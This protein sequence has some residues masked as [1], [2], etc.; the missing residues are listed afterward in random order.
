MCGCQ[1]R[2]MAAAAMLAHE[3]LGQESRMCMQAC[4]DEHRWRPHLDRNMPAARLGVAAGP[5]GNLGWGTQVCGRH[6][7]SL[8]LSCIDS[9]MAHVA[10]P[11]DPRA[12]QREKV[13]VTMLT[14][15]I[16]LMSGMDTAACSQRRPIASRGSAS[17]HD[18]YADQGSSHT[19]ARMSTG[20][21]LKLDA[22]ESRRNHHE[23]CEMR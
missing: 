18:H 22:K 23:N 6:G 2:Q 13:L 16:A 21:E 11:Q 15:A 14:I 4:D 8:G 3:G 1:K 17:A 20:S 12:Q 7:Q 5:R 10:P 19:S 9:A